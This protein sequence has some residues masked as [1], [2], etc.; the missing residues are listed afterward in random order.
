MD[1]GPSKRV[2]RRTLLG[3]QPGTR[4]DVPDGRVGPIPARMGVWTTLKC[5]VDAARA[6]L[7]GAEVQPTKLMCELLVLGEDHRIGL[8]PGVD[9]LALCR[10][11][12]RTYVK[13]CREGGSTVAMQLV[14]VLTGRFE[15]NWR[16][17][18]EE[19][20]LAVLLT[21]YVPRDELPSLYLSVGY[22][23]WRM[24]GFAQACRR[25][26]FDPSQCSVRDTA[27]L[28][29]RLK[30]PQPR[31]CSQERWGQIIRR[32]EYLMARHAARG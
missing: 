9:P 6:D 24:N 3:N 1:L 8:H 14:R 5:A 30:Y 16:R 4:L 27:M 7:E 31:C 21:R 13:D 22:Y 10:A 20:G 26:R 28:I 2:V 23:G 29:A 32:C 15:R 18:T 25:L 19:I 12:W 17:K 11:G